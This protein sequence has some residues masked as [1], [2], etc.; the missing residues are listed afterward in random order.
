MDTTGGSI[1]CTPP[2]NPVDGEF[3]VVFDIARQWGAHTPI[4]GSSADSFLWTE[5]P[6]A[7]PFEFTSQTGPP[8]WAPMEVFVWDAAISAWSIQY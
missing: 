5:G 2:P 4:V 7:G 6:A 3:F 8:G 1:T